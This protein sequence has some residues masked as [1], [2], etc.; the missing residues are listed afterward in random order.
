MFS[1]FL[2]KS[3]VKAVTQLVSKIIPGITVL[4]RFLEVLSDLVPY[5]N[6][7]GRYYVPDEKNGLKVY[8]T[9]SRPDILCLT[10]LTS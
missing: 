4:S 5:E 3:A 7:S 2:M 9:P 1:R 8:I 10:F 6:F